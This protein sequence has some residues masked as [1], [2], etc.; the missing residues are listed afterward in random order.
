MDSA[1]HHSVTS[2]QRLVLNVME[3]YGICVADISHKA[4]CSEDAVYNSLD[5]INFQHHPLIEVLRVRAAIEV[6]L[7]EAGCTLS[8]SSLWMEYDK[9]IKQRPAAYMD[10]KPPA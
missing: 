6:A 7:R 2:I 8:R 3:K 10:H 4:N 5:L 9:K 1:S